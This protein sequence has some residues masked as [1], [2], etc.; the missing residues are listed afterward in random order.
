MIYCIFEKHFVIFSLEKLGFF[1]LPCNKTA[2][3]IYDMLSKVEKFIRND[4]RAGNK[5]PNAN[6]FKQPTPQP[7]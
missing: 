6:Y 7:L 2:Y 5:I 1:I 3:K 4:V